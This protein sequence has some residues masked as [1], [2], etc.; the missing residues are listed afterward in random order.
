MTKGSEVEIRHG[1]A[2]GSDGAAVEAQA[3]AAAVP[4]VD[5]GEGDQQRRIDRGGGGENGGDR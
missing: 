3:V 5:D 4:E 1:V 2:C